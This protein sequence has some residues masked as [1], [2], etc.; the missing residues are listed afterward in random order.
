[1]RNWFKTLAIG[2]GA[3]TMLMT[4]AVS[5]QNIRLGT[6]NV[7]HQTHTV[8]YSSVPS[9][10][11]WKE[12]GLNVQ[13]IGLGGANAAIEALDSGQVDVAAPATSAVFALLQARP[14]SDLVAFYTFTNSFNALPAVPKDSPV[15]RVRDLSGK[16]IGVQNLANSQVALTKAM[17]KLDGGDP[18]SL[19]FIA[20]GEGA[21]SVRAL[22]TRQIDAIAIFDSV[23]ALIEAEG[24]PLRILESD[25]VNKDKVG[26]VGV[27]VTKRAYFE[28]NRDALIKLG[29]GVAKATV[30]A[31]A[32][33]EAAVRVHWAMFPVTKQRGVSEEAAM[34]RSILP[35][36]ARLANVHDVEGMI[37]NAT[38]E[39]IKGYQN[40][41]L[42]GGVLK[43]AVDTGPL[44][45][46]SLLKDINNFDRQAIVKLA[47]QGK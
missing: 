15:R 34:R 6:A 18:D 37:G 26:F 41:L 39:Q 44:W 4:G 31:K 36:Q 22:Q 30:Y 5:A 14:Q 8:T 24:V 1:M 46:A 28:K 20:V 9:T 23:Y 47:E 3:A 2:V 10:Y 45:N 29:R 40:L 25:Q 35:M 7:T 12:E 11:F 38:A 32:N 19:K 33:P 17:V 27:L 13:L 16:T 21:E 42:E 43:K